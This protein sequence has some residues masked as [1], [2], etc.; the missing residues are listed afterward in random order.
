MKK[1]VLI[2]SLILLFTSISFISAS[3]GTHLSS[4]INIIVD[5]TSKSL[6][7][8]TSSDAI[9]THTYSAGTSIDPG[10]NANQI[11]VSVKDG[12]M[13]L[14]S[15]LQ[16]TDKLCPANPIESLYISASIPN[17]SHIATEINLANG[18]TFQKAINDG[19]YCPPPIN[20]GWGTVITQACSPTT[21]AHTSYY[22]ETKFCDN[23]FPANGGANC[24]A[25]DSTWTTGIL[26]GITTDNGITVPKGTL[27]ESK[28][29]WDC[30]ICTSNVGQSC[31]T[32]CIKVGT[33]NCTG[34]CVASSAKYYE[35]KGTDCGEGNTDGICD[36]KGN[37]IGWSGSGCDSCPFG[38]VVDN[39]PADLCAWTGNS[40]TKYCKLGTGN[41]G[42]WCGTQ[43]AS[44]LPW[45]PYKVMCHSIEPGFMCIGQISNTNINWKIK[46]AA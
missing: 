44:C 40:E 1:S 24:V 37:C 31:T 11:W 5:G 4:S 30:Q 27:Y 35:A 32:D 21:G 13:T 33:I 10:H 28:L 14:L 38:S 23:P 43:W 29:H 22:Y 25:D 18:K 45:E 19:D 41:T 26:G 15:A 17:P 2:F 39:G 34:S 46:P 12:E 9:G 42:T 20:G 6:N 7:S 36:G 8:F 16:S 3:G